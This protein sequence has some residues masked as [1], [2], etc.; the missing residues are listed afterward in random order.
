MGQ[1]VPELDRPVQLGEGG[2]RLA[3]VVAELALH[4]GRGDAE[5]MAISSSAVESA[6]AGLPRTIAP[7]LW[8]LQS[9]QRWA[10]TGSRVPHDRGT[11]SPRLWHALR[12]TKFEWSP[13]SPSI[14]VAMWNRWPAFGVA[15][16]SG[17]AAADAG[18]GQR[19]SR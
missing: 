6:G 3:L 4:H 16:L 17:S 7:E 9:R 10:V 11:R 5:S 15:T 18:R 19:M 13:E 2:I 14:R 12:L 1:G 8:K